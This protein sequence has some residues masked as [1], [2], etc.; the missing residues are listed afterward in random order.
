MA[1]SQLIAN[2]DGLAS[3]NTIFICGPPNVLAQSLSTLWR[4]LL[5]NVITVSGR[6][7]TLYSGLITLWVQYP[8][9]A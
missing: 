7:S 1:K 6:I 2:H 4:E 9:M 8:G 3:I 5:A